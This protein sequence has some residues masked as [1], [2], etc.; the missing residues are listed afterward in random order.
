[1]KSANTAPCLPTAGRPPGLASA[2]LTL[3]RRSPEREGREPPGRPPIAPA[4]RPHSRR[5]GSC[6]ERRTG[7]P[8]EPIPRP[9]HLDPALPHSPLPGPPPRDLRR[10][11]YAT[12]SHAPLHRTTDSPAHEQ[13]RKHPSAHVHAIGH[14]RRTETRR[15]RRPSVSRG[16]IGRH[17]GLPVSAEPDRGSRRNPSRGVAAATGCR[18]GAE[19]HS[20]H[21]AFGLPGLPDH[22]QEFVDRDDRDAE[23]SGLLCL[24]GCR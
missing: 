21:P 12:S 5:P 4:P 7:P 17:G 2:R 6:R 11:G 10:N 1:M 15:T 16:C 22:R 3:S 18:S 9:R 13:R 20:G 8:A 19:S 23:A 24:A 14:R